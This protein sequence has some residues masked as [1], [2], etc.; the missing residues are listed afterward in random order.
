MQ[1]TFLPHDEQ[2]KVI[3]DYRLRVAIVG[4]FFVAVACMIGAGALFPAYISAVI[5]KSGIVNKVEN[6]RSTDQSRRLTVAQQE[7]AK[8]AT[9]LQAISE[10][11]KPSRY[12]GLINDIS[13]LRGSVT[14]DSFALDMSAPS[15]YVITI[16]GIA[17]V[18]ADLLSFKS[19]LVE[20]LGGAQVDLPYSTLARDTKVPYSMKITIHEAQP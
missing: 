1:Y 4:L 11:T 15:G 6:I 13:K 2:K 5:E 3:C 17:P 7:L 14:I 12:S 10:N 19:K 18:R 20:R 9:L 16:S 8:G